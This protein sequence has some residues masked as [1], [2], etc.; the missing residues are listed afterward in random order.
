MNIPPP[1]NPANSAPVN[2]RRLIVKGFLTG[3]FFIVVVVVVLY[4]LFVSLAPVPGADNTAHAVLRA[5]LLGH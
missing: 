3:L 5:L 2:N 4:I 1:L